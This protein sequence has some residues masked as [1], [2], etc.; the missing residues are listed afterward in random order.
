M[1]RGIS[2]EREISLKGG[3]QVFMA[4][5]K[6]KYNVLRYDPEKDIERLVK[7]AEKI[8]TALIILHGTGGEDGSIQGLLDLLKIPYQGSGILG[9]AVAINKLLSK[10]LYKQAG[11]DVPPYFSIFKDKADSADE[12]SV[13]LGFP[14]FIKPVKGGSSIGMSL[15]KRKKELKQAL[16]KA[17]AHDNNIIMEKCIDGIEV[18][19]SVIG[20]EMLEAL[21]VV[22]IRPEKGHEFFDFNAKY[23]KNA[24][25]GI[26]PAHI[27][28]D[29][30]IRAKDCAKKAHRVLFC[31]GYS[32]TDMI[33]KKEKIYILETNT[34]PGM[35]TNSL[36]PIAA[37][38]S[39]ISFSRLLDILIELSIKER[40]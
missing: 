9:S 26:C 21:P 7:D 23:T 17:F 6:K 20:N 10:Q 28:E 37:K 27:D 38:N 40:G 33:I 30:T 18:T 11:L 3:D 15:V 31:K 25:K 5:D 8:D 2:T 13:S 12:Y 35:T 24:A 36:L 14:I 1:P 22:E 29:L 32:R 16:D 4:L 39:G 19:G 34:I